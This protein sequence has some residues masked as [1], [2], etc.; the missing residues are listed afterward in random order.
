M[1]CLPSVS[2]PLSTSCLC[3]AL[4][5]LACLG[6]T[7]AMRPDRIA[8]LRRDTVDMFYHGYDNYMKVAFPDDEVCLHSAALPGLIARR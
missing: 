8:S 6:Q 4:W 1:A 5:L 2:M 3:I 7:W